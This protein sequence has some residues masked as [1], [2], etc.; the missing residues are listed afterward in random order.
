M[1][2]LYG[3]V[4]NRINIRYNGYSYSI[5]A[6]DI[7]IEGETNENKLFVAIENLFNI[8]PNDLSGYVLDFEDQ[9]SIIIRPNTNLGL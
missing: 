2:T 5:Y 7:N 8:N 1:V 3:Q 6:E 4:I 9:G